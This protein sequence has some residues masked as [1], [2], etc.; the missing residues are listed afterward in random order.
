MEFDSDDYVNQIVNSPRSIMCITPQN[1]FGESFSLYFKDYLLFTLQHKA[2]CKTLK[3]ILNEELFVLLWNI[4]GN[5]IL[6][7]STGS[8]YG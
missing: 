5:H 2:D 8:L 1:Y 3:F 6:P 7:M 4:D